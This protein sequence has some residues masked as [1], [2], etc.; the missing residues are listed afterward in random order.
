MS[1]GVCTYKDVYDGSDIVDLTCFQI[2]LL[3]V[4][5]ALPAKLLFQPPLALIPSLKNS[6]KLAPLFLQGY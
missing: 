4:E 5:K 6:G 2:P 3:N 1:K